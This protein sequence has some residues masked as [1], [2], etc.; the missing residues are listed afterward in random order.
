MFIIV[1]QSNKNG[2]LVSRK[3]RVRES[4]DWVRVVLRILVAYYSDSGN[5]EKI[6]R[7]IYEEVSVGN[8]AQLKKIK[9]VKTE[10]F[11]DYDVVFVGGPCQ[12]NDL[13]SPVKKLLN[14]VP[15]SPKFKLAGFF[16][17]MSPSGAKGSYERCIDSFEKIR[18]EKKIDF[19][20]YYECQGKPTPQV[21]QF[22]RKSMNVPEDVFKKGMAEAKNHPSA[23]DLKKAK[24]F[25]RGIVSKK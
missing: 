2:I 15:V 9:D 3:K 24:E 6:A 14:L 10:D 11:S 7:A 1:F 13:A 12:V 8:Q 17:H 19:K 25:A 21:E 23:E 18:K 20:G 22:V 5:T 16:T 4:I